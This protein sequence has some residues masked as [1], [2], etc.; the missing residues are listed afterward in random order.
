MS[1]LVPTRTLESAPA[2]GILAVSR[3]AIGLALGLL[4]AGKFR[5][6]ARQAT[7]ITLL[8]AGLLANLPSV[9]DA[10]ERF[11]NRPES[12]RGSQR[13]L[14]SIRR[15]VDVPVEDMQEHTY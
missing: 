8:S 14:R 7:A 4:L 2:H 10:I 12:D 6:G 11:V 13:R 9:A 3:A 15:D 1:I 5:P